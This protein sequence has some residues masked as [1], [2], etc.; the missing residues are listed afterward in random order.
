L[1]VITKW[2]RQCVALQPDI[3][4]TGQRVVDA[5]SA[6]ACER[7]PPFAIIVDNGTEFTSKALDEWCYFR[8]VKLDF[9]RPGQPT[10]NSMIGSFNGRLRDECLNMNEFP[11]LDEVRTVLRAS[12]RGYNNCRPH[13][14]LGNLTPSEYGSRRSEN[15][16]EATNSIFKYFENQTNFNGR[17]MSTSQSQ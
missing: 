17:I 1:T 12:R 7:D 14:S 11:T 9:S 10:E 3:A 15:D 16:P 6:V 5:L 13:G 2:H 4:L 8:G